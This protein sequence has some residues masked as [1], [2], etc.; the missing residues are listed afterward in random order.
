[1]VAE[2]LPERQKRAPGML[3]VALQLALEGIAL[4][5]RLLLGGLAA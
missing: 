1:M 4:P 2:T 3:A 5:F